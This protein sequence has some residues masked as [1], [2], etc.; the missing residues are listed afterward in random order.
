MRVLVDGVFDLTHFGHANLFAHVKHRMFEG[1][2]TVVAGVTADEDAAT[3]KRR[4][5]MTYAERARA[6]GCFRDVDEVLS[7]P[8]IV[9]L[10]FLDAHGLDCVC[11]DGTPYACGDVADV[12]AE[13]RAAGRFRATPRTPDVS[14]TQLIRRIREPTSAACATTRLPSATNRVTRIGDGTYTFVWKAYAAGESLQ[15][16]RE[17]LRGHPRLTLAVLDD[18]NACL[19]WCG[20]A[21]TPAAF[22]AAVA[23]VVSELRRD[24]E[25]LAVADRTPWVHRAWLSASP[26]YARDLARLQHHLAVAGM[27]NPRAHV[28]CHL[29][30]HGGNV[31]RDADGAL[32]VI[33]WEFASYA[34]PCVEWGHLAS[35]LAMR[36][37]WTARSTCEDL[38]V[39]IDL[40]VGAVN[41][42]PHAALRHRVTVGALHACLMWIHWSATCAEPERFVG[43]ARA[44]Q[45]VFN[46]LAARLDG[47]FADGVPR[48]GENL[49]TKETW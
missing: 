12:Y 40:V 29:D 14:T 39:W 15:R 3:H 13:L 46:R 20:T 21:L 31:L 45:T 26:A 38:D 33:D 25:R 47:S 4:P 22:A 36:G 9:T 44:Q 6:V 10:D 17:V 2:I 23:D 27:A 41:D 49:Q 43:F 35:H 30:V 42:S 18:R 7:I 24:H 48:E 11:H 5:I 37:E 8:W 32:I 16:E 19:P 1:P 28:L 34:H